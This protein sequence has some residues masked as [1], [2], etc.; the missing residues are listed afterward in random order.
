MVGHTGVWDATLAALGA[1][2]IAI[3]RVADA[4]AGVEAADPT[5]P[6][7]VLLITADHGNADAAARSRRQSR[8]GTLAQPRAA[9]CRGSRGGRRR[10]FIDG[11]LADVAPTILE[12]AGSGA[13]TA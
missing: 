5:G 13:G 6:G 12:L 8:D 7:A 11:L 10:S 3:G 2:D 9:A 1:V 4:I